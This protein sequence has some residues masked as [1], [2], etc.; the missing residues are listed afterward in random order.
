MGDDAKAAAQRSG[1]GALARR[2]AEYRAQLGIEESDLAARA[3]MAPRYLE[4]LLEAGTD[5]DPNGLLRVAAVL[6]LTYQELI[7]GRNDSPPG[8]AGPL[9]RPVLLNLT[10]SECWNRIGTHGLG[11]IAVP[12]R[13]GPAVIPVNYA[14]DAGTIVYRTT[15]HGPAAPETGTE[16][17]FQVDR[18]DDRLSQGW[19][20]FVTGTA[21]RIDD[22]ATVERL[23]EA[24]T[25]RPWAVGVR[26][27]WMRVRPDTVA[28]RRIAT[29]PVGPS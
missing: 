10:T 28:G 11:R 6:G 29:A 24:H 8:Q 7:E 22:P 12:V 20:V 4:Q 21:E 5:F 25:G 9:P 14:V 15:S 27:R 3:G 23:A 1:P 26:P 2:V 17:I 19:S 13:P 16:V 18:I